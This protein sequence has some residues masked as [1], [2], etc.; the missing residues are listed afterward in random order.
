L[1]ARSLL[2]VLAGILIAGGCAEDIKSPKDPPKRSAAALSKWPPIQR[3]SLQDLAGDG[4]QD[5][6]TAS[7]R[8]SA[9]RVY[10][11]SSAALRD[12][13]SFFSI[14]EPD[15]QDSD[16]SPGESGVVWDCRNAFVGK[17]GKIFAVD[18]GPDDYV[19]LSELG[20]GGQPVRIGCGMRVPMLEVVSEIDTGHR[21]ISGTAIIEVILG[22]DGRVRDA[23]LL[24]PLASQA[25][26]GAALELVEGARFRPAALFGIPVPVVHNFTVEVVEGRARIG[27][28]RVGR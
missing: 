18:R 28:R 7:D 25:A 8:A 5:C 20:I 27:G 1:V 23:R 19:S 26:N 17:D 11:C 4:A 3:S 15:S 16:V 21:Q 13:R 12:G 14:F 10:D 24:K 22:I 6:G 2:A 9:D